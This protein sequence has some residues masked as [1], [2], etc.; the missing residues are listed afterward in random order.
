MYNI[1]AAIFDVESEG[2]QAMTQLSR[3]PI[4]EETSILQMVLV[5]RENGTL[6]VCDSYDSG[7]HTTDNT[8]LG[9]LLG[10]LVGVLGGPVGML[11]M[12]SYGA[13]V[14]S[15]VDTGD[16]LDTQTL[17]ERVADKLQDGDVALIMLAEE[18][19]EEE[20]D[21]AL[22]GFKVTIA[23]FDAAAIANEV[24]MIEDSQKEKERLDRKELREAK[25]EERKDKLEA[26]KAEIGADFAAFKSRFK[27]S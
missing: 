19:N 27:K 2:Y 16:A 5:K 17:M 13:L 3:T 14:G 18:I 25:K 9:G 1:I 7:A 11:L 12:G 4:I 23:R 6:K 22:K 20:V 24:E 15:L 21:N 8:L 10:G 26:K